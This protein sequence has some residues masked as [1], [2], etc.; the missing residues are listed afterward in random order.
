MVLSACGVQTLFNF[1]PLMKL[2]GYYLLSDWLEIPNLQ[3]RAG[4]YFKGWL[5]RLLW[6]AA[7]P[8]REPRGRCLLT[9]GLVSWLYS[10]TF[11]SLSLTV[12]F[13]FLSTRLGLLGLAAVALLG[14]LS[15]RGL[16]HGFTAGEVRTMILIRHKRTVIWICLLGGVPAALFCVQM[17]DRAAGRSSSVRRCVRRSAPRW[18]ASSK[19]STATRATGSRPGQLLIRWTCPTWPAGWPRSGPSCARRRPSCACWRS[20]PG[21]RRSPSNDSGWNEPRAWRDLATKDLE[22]AQQVL[23]ATWHAW[24]ITSTNMP[25]SWTSPRPHGP[26][27]EASGQRGACRAGASGSGEEM[28]A[29]A[30]RSGSRP[31]RTS[32]PAR[33]RDAGGR[34]RGRPPRE[35]TG[36]GPGDPG[37]LEAGTRPEEIEAERAHLARLDAEATYLEALQKK[38]PVFSPAAGVITTPLSKEKVGQYLR[39][40]DLI[41]VVEESAGLEAEIALTEQDVARVRRGP[42]GPS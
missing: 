1:N 39:E 35:G 31:R 32:G 11:L 42:G 2:D 15:L 3:Q 28:P 4:D 17:E 25:P 41:C 33:R 40:G 9:Y 5:R 21:T 38:E 30:E 14:L 34:G 13:Q 37:L 36:R 27:P 7:R 20:G 18:P 10:L 22:R 29:C 26:Q 23:E 12:M 19:S 16:L 24:Q 8:E 6:G